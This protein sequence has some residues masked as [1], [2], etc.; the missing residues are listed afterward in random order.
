MHERYPRRPAD[1]FPYQTETLGWI[2]LT[3]S[4]GMIASLC[5]A[6]TV[7][8]TPE[9]TRSNGVKVLGGRLSACGDDP[10][11]VYIRG[12]YCA[13]HCPCRRVV[14]AARLLRSGVGAGVPILAVGPVCCM[15]LTARASGAAYV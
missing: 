8:D 1:E 2:T 3:R 11:S 12:E 10:S 15:A 4:P 13:A 6:I 14:A 9:W 5:G 7:C